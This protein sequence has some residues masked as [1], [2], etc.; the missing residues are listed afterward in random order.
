MVVKTQLADIFRHELQQVKKEILAHVDKQFDNLD[1]YNKGEVDDR[2]YVLEKEA[3]GIMSTKVD[4]DDL[5]DIKM[6][7]E[8]YAKEEIMEMGIKVEKCFGKRLIKRLKASSW[9][10][11]MDSDSK[12]N[13]PSS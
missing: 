5:D 9:N 12:T 4:E 10:L 3:E 13:L 8:V 7:L 1:M 11:E 2:F 6:E